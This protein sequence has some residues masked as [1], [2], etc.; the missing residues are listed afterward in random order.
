MDS[1]NMLVGFL[2]QR[3]RFQGPKTSPGLCLMSSILPPE[4]SSFTTKL[5]GS[6]S[7]ILKCRE[8]LLFMLTKI[9]T[10][11]G[12][13]GEGENGGRNLVTMMNPFFTHIQK[14][15]GWAWKFWNQ[16][17]RQVAGTWAYSS[18]VV[19]WSIWLQT[20]T[21]EVTGSNPVGSSI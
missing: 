19:W 17:L 14:V 1:N 11:Q 20:K 6:R 9:F 4:S 3:A 13:L 18:V 5:G 15:I 2:R 16:K 10:R 7:L 12:S 8:R 21:Q